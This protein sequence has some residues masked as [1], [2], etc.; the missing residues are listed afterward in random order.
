[1]ETRRHR[2][3]RKRLLFLPLSLLCLAVLLLSALLAPSASAS[4][5]EAAAAAGGS[6]KRRWVGFDYY[7]LA[8]QWP[9]TI[10]RQTSN[11]C[12]SNGCCRYHFACHLSSHCHS[13]NSI[14]SELIW[15]S[16]TLSADRSLLNGLRFVSPRKSFAFSPIAT[17]Q[18]IVNSL[19]ILAL[20]HIVY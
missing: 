13:W 4:S 20:E 14:E 1:M 9:G 6:R 12:D 7:V 15:F 8:L 5:P 18:Y 11:C 19:R 10:C 17:E 2:R 3:G 16:L